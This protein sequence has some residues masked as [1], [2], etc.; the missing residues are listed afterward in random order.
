M[1]KEVLIIYDADAEYVK[2]FAEYVNQMS[3]A[4]F[5]V[6][7]FTDFDTMFQYMQERNIS[8]IL[9]PEQLLCAEILDWNARILLLAD[10]NSQDNKYDFEQIWKYQ[11]G[12]NIIREVTSYYAQS[13]KTVIQKKTACSQ[14]KIYG[15]Y[16]PVHRCGVTSFA[17]ALTH[18]LREKKKALYIN[19]EEFSGLKS[20]FQGEYLSDLSD[21]LYFFLQ[22]RSNMDL[23]LKAT[24]YSSQWID[25][26]PP[27]RYSADIRNIGMDIWCEF[28]E[29]IGLWSDYEVLILDISNM[30][31][32]VMELFGICDRIFV[33]YLGDEISER[34][35]EEFEMYFQNSEYCR[36]HE[37]VK[38]FLLEREEFF[39]FNL[40]QICRGMFAEFVKNIAGDVIENE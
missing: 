35:I 9:L 34:K 36:Y 10:E 5:S 12:D 40:E 22:N 7:A 8:V 30:L 31:Q 23:K 2:A 17:L 38:S 14:T 27:M 29:S 37:K 15:V 26:I 24:V 33:P 16:S 18:L 19:L 39:D 4:A 25:Y 3:D 11:S 1:K 32:N 6:A 20:I 13:K 28:I 21:L